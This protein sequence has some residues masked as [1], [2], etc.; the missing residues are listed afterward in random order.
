MGSQGGG[1]LLGSEHQ[2][3]AGEQAWWGQQARA[4]VVSCAPERG[5]WE[6]SLDWGWG[7]RPWEGWSE[8]Q[9]HVGHWAHSEKSA[10]SMY[11]VRG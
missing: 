6:K 11:S 8:C 3:G 7:V 10:Q 4:A 1:G 9:A 2:H 5:V